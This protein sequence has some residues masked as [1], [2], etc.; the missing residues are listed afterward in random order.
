[1]NKRIVQNIK[2]LPVHESLYYLQYYVKES[3]MIYQKPLAPEMTFPSNTG[4]AYNP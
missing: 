1:M 4:I 3:A 2:I